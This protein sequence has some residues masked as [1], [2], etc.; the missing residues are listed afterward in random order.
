[1]VVILAPSGFLQIA[2]SLFN[3]VVSSP[4]TNKE[5]APVGKHIGS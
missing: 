3:R 5:G 1:V 2:G 4:K